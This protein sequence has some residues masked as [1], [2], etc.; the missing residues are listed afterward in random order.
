MAEKKEISN[1]AAYCGKMLANM[2]K[3]EYRANDNQAKHTTPTG[4]YFDGYTTKVSNETDMEYLISGQTAEDWLRFI[5]NERLHYALISLKSE[6]LEFIFT[7]YLYGFTERQMA[8]HLGV[9]RNAV[10][11]RKNRILS[12]MKKYLLGGVQKEG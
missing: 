7:F 2:K 4:I 11:K 1:I 10:H 6:D 5:E 9:N 8:E 3:N 12:K